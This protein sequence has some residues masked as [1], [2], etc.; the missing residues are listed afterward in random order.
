MKRYYPFIIIGLTLSGCG[1]GAVAAVSFG[2]PVAIEAYR[3]VKTELICP[4]ITEAGKQAVRDELT[5]G[6]NVYNYCP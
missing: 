4:G 3:A 6:K 5:D 1:S 2:L